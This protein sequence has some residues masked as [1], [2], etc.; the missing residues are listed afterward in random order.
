MLGL[1]LS[2]GAL[3]ACVAG[4]GKDVGTGLHVFV[5]AVFFAKQVDGF[6]RDTRV[7]VVVYLEV[8]LAQKFGGGADPDIELFCYFI[9]LDWH[10][11]IFKFLC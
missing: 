8:M 9:Y 1:S 7:G 11:L 3:L 2:L 10:R 4:V 6:I 5:F